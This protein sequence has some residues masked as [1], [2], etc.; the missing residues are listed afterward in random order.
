[1]RHLSEDQSAMRFASLLTIFALLAS[2]VPVTASGSNGK[3]AG[4]KTVGVEAVKL[5][6]MKPIALWPGVAPGDKGDIGEEK[7]TS[8][9]KED[10]N[11]PSY[12]IR[13]G[14]VSRP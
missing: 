11:S 1:M 6:P 12:V 3:P 8:D 4:R 7:D 5:E 9:P 13:L 10:R 2:L 14:N